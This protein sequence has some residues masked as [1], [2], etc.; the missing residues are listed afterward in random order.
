MLRRPVAILSR[1]IGGARAEHARRPT[2]PA[3]TADRFKLS[4][5][6]GRGG[7]IGQSAIDVGCIVVLVVAVLI[8]GL[9]VALDLPHRI[10]LLAD[11][12]AV[13][14][15][16]W[17]LI[18]LARSGST[19]S[20]P[21]LAMAL[22]VVLVVAAFRSDDFI[23]LLVSAR[24]F[25]LPPMLALALASLGERER[26]NRALVLAVVGLAVVEFA[27]TVLQSITI[28]NV[29]LIGGTFGDYSQQSVAFAIIAGACLA[30]SV[31]AA[32]VKGAWWLALA[33]VLPAF[34]I[35]AVI[36]S[37]LPIAPVAG[38]AVVV[39]AW[40]VRA[41]HQPLGRRWARPAVTA[42]A[43]IFSAIAI[44]AGFAIARPRDFALFTNSSERST[45]LHQATIYSRAGQWTSVNGTIT[46]ARAYGLSG[47][48]SF[49]VTPFGGVPYA[50]ARADGVSPISAGRTYS[51]L[52]S[53]RASSA[54]RYQLWAGTY[55]GTEHRGP[56]T[57]LAAD[58]WTPM[59]VQGVKITATG[60][61]FLAL[62][63]PSGAYSRDESISFA[64]ITVTKGAIAREPQAKGSPRCSSEQSDPSTSSSANG[65]DRQSPA[66]GGGGRKSPAKGGGGRKSAAHVSSSASSIPGRLDQYKTAARLISGRP[67]SFL[68]GN[69]LGSTTY[70]E[71]LGIAPPSTDERS[72]GYSDVGTLIVEIG[73]LGVALA[74]AS[75]V[76]L[77]TGSL[78]AARRAKPA[79]WTQ[80]LLIGYP[81]VLVTMVALAFFGAPFRN[82]GSAT[83]FWLLTGLALASILGRRDRRGPSGT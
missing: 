55:L 40:W 2:P 29:D 10:E 31:Y 78:A 41:P 52:A 22:A 17:I 36:R 65:G 16:V 53:V 12:A 7:T 57:R 83:I 37:A 79:S 30:L 58:H 38:M 71:N 1:V 15:L 6:L 24:N 42:T 74:V 11:L 82:V 23:R 49:S 19:L 34:L 44:T 77:G 33:M 73:W 20:V 66:K 69:G 81:G 25:V 47:Q 72:A 9:A 18:N 5:S 56:V 61:L 70:A 62:W 21:Y 50:G 26:R 46:D 60:P 13:V 35:W 27:I 8:Q 43:V 39:G 75:A 54:G 80:A 67:A 14:L 3:V 4:V 48:A 45:Y 59:R 64:C 32:R 51:F 28:D 76:A 63:K 68:F